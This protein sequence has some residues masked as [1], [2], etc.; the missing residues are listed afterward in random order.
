[1]HRPR[2]VSLRYE[3]L[4]DRTTPT[5]ITVTTA[6]DTYA[7]DGLVSLREA[8]TAANTNA[9][10]NGD[11]P[12][13]Q[14]G[15]DTI[16]FAIPGTGVQVLTLSSSLPS[17]A[18]PVVIDGY[19]QPG[20]APNTLAVGDNATILIEVDAAGQGAFTQGGT[21][22]G[23]VFQ[24]LSVV[25]ASGYAINMQFQS[26]V[27][28]RGDFLGVHADGVTARGNAAGVYVSGTGG[29]LIGGPNP[30][31]RNI[32]S[33][34]NG[35]GVVVAGSNA[36]VQGNYVGTTR[37]G[38]IAVANAGIGINV[39]SG[40][41]DLIGGGS[42]GARNIVSGNIQHGIYVSSP[43]TSVQGNYVGT[44]V[45]GSFAIPNRGYGVWLNG[46][47]A[48]CVVGGTSPGQG[49]LIS[50]NGQ[51]GLHSWGTGTLIQGNFIGTNA[52]GT[53]AIPNGL[54]GIATSGT[55]TIGGTAAG[56]GNLISGNVQS[57]IAVNANDTIQGNRIGVAADG[58]SPLPN[59]FY[60]V[61]ITSGTNM[62]VG[63]TAAG[64]GNVIAYNGLDGIRLSGGSGDTFAQNSIY[65]NGGLGI[66]YLNTVVNHNQ[67]APVL[68][69]A[70]RGPNVT[71][72]GTLTSG[73]GTFRIEFFA[74]HAADPTGVGEGEKYLG[75]VNVTTDSTGKGSFSATLTVPS[76]YRYVSATATNN[77]TFDTSPFSNALTVPTR[78]L[79]FDVNGDG[80]DDL[81]GRSSSGQWW[82]TTGA[83]STG[84]WATWNESLGWQ[85][86]KEGDF[87]G[88]GKA[89]V[90][91]RTSTGQWYVTLGGSSAVTAWGPAW[92]PSAGWHST[93]QGDFNGDG[94][95]DIASRDSSGT[96]WVAVSTGT[97]FVTANWGHWNEAA[98]WRDVKAGDFDGDGLDDIAGRD[99]AGNWWVAK[100]NGSNKF[101]TT[102]W[103]KW[104]ESLG[105]ADVSS[106]DFN[107]DGKL[108]IA[109]RDSAGDWMVEVSSVSNSVPVFTLQTWAHWNPSA[110]WH[111]I[112]VGDFNGDGKDDIAERDS[113]G[114]WWVG[115]STGTLFN[116][117]QPWTKWDE[118]LGWTNV[119]VGDFDGD[120][121]MDVA[122]MASSG[123]W[124]VNL[125]GTSQFTKVA[126]VTWVPEAKWH[127]V[128]NV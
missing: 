72:R 16:Q 105:W 101:A 107:G 19:S 102:V 114:N 119:R 90:A 55:N 96:W 111:G 48:G 109:G 29:D 89:D 2:S 74:N 10:V 88:D 85:D 64:A 82:Q 98:G 57:G 42:A 76:G 83:N 44:D 21:I 8:I 52:A 28:I 51:D 70:S 22:P 27:T 11:T 78:R 7:H 18:E 92:N 104:T 49:N 128:N 123:A 115:V 68:T 75:F 117:G 35:D 43:N 32:I 39:I 41:N 6:A 80:K 94:K 13:G 124:T 112:C 73:A 121:K 23:S 31:D 91:G 4:E 116:T 87:N 26:S 67:A 3:R 30:G 24:G 106:G 36:T 50:G 47:P 84:Y 86:V 110:G 34:N 63:G 40:P 20:S 103:G 1:M 12:A 122:G 60:G 53:V 97:S 95:E 9:V 56:A 127:D 59:G 14:A 5:V 61:L 126:W 79:T 62:S 58:K 120:G 69:T 66:A 45:S 118:S 33:G 15:L 99:S 65:S 37:D 77:A 38:T 93:V 125:G 17:I 100:S 54:S 108:D 81:A 71:V 25:N 46:G 113:G